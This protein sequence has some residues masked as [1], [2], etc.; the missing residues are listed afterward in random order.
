MRKQVIIGFKPN[1]VKEYYSEDK[2]CFVDSIEDATIFDSH[3][4]AMDVW[5]EIAPKYK[6]E[7]MNI[8]VVIHNPDSNKIES[9]QLRE[10]YV[11]QTV[12]DF[13]ELISEVDVIDNI[14]IS[15]ISKN[16]YDESIIFQGSYDE[17]MDR[18][19][20]LNAEFVEFDTGGEGVTLNVGYPSGDADYTYVA[21]II[22]DCNEEIVTIFSFDDNDNIFN[23]YKEDLD[24]EIL[25]MYFASMDCPNFLS[26]NVKGYDNYEDDYLTE[27]KDSEKSKRATKL[28]AEWLDLTEFSLY[29]KD[30]VYGLI[31]NQHAN[32]GDIERDRFE[33]ASQILD[34][35]GIYVEDYIFTDLEE[36][37]DYFDVSFDI[38]WSR[39]GW[40]KLR[41][42]KEVYNENKEFFKDVIFHL[43]FLQLI[44]DLIEE[45]NLVDLDKVVT[46][47]WDE[48]INGDAYSEDDEFD[49]YDNEYD[50]EE[51]LNVKEDEKSITE[52]NEGLTKEDL[53]NDILKFVKHKKLTK[54]EFEKELKKLSLEALQEL[55]VKAIE[56]F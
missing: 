55:W 25:D 49:S 5:Y 35:M 30:G 32:L 34:R 10:S 37:A 53:I 56:T 22:E 14:I 24:D 54:E 9:K 47:N 11:G 42:N 38:P 1:K 52:E 23:G 13:L 8:F 36:Q 39:E 46:D 16:N 29:K 33:N 6:K 26:I 18:D 17:L 43:D 41:N 4:E 19:D 15:D 12:E 48:N 3:A 31:D 28:F 27:D 40:L 21:D 7:Y 2:G 45:P 20:L 51:K 44:E 50:F